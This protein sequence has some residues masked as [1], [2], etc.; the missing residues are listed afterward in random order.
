ML[1]GDFE[2]MQELASHGPSTLQLQPIRPQPYMC[3][4]LPGLPPWQALHSCFA[5]YFGEFL[6]DGW[7]QASS[8]GV[9]LHSSAI[10]PALGRYF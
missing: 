9:P 5:D 2:T 8:L 7:E 1:H 10:F 6:L 4:H 3:G